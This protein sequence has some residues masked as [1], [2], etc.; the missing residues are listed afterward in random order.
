MKH[1]QKISKNCC[2]GGS[3]ASCREAAVVLKLKHD[4]V[5]KFFRSCGYYL[6]ARD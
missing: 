6:N 5:L 3:Q 1:N 4:G 2:A